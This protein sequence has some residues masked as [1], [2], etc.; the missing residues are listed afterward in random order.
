MGCL[1]IKLQANMSACEM[2]WV[3]SLLTE[4][5]FLVLSTM[6]M[7]YEKQAD[8]FIVNNPTFYEHTKNIDIEARLAFQV[9]YQNNDCSE[10]C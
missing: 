9:F 6:Q 1:S 5:V 10:R 7:F 2:L 4:L 3:H 8:I